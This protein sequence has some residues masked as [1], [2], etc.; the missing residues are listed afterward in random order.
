[1]AE[2][3]QEDSP[4]EP[5]SLEY[6]EDSYVPK[7][8]HNATP[9]LDD[10]CEYDECDDLDDIYN[11]DNVTWSKET[12][13][14]LRSLTLDQ[15]LSVP[16]DDLSVIDENIEM[17]TVEFSHIENSPQQSRN[18]FES[19]KNKWR[20]LTRRKM[21]DIRVTFIDLSKPYILKISSSDNYKNFL[22]IGGTFFLIIRH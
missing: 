3:E 5:S 9:S 12:D 22:N 13:L 4:I 1:M 6:I 15:I 11:D 14:F 21:R 20:L 18:F 7:L 10:L 19:T 8:E 16:D 17:Q 2:M